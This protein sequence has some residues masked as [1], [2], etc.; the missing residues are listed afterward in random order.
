MFR[1]CLRIQT[2]LTLSPP[3]DH[4]LMFMS[5]QKWTVA[6]LK[7]LDE[8]NKVIFVLWCSE[9]GLDKLGTQ[10]CLYLVIG[11]CFP[12]CEIKLKMTEKN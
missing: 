8:M 3:K 12:N 10:K 5:D 1:Y 2:N 9:Y 4:P 7:L 6:L 11:F